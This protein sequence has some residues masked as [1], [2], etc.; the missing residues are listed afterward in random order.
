MQIS[1][2]IN[3]SKVME[4]IIPRTKIAQKLNQKKYSKDFQVSKKIS[5]SNSLIQLSRKR[6]SQK[7]TNG[8]M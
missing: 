5:R 3:L 8:R 2:I 6:I 4:A 1:L 7:T